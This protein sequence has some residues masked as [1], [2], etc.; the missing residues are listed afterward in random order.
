MVSPFFLDPAGQSAGYYGEDD[1]SLSNGQRAASILFKSEFSLSFV[2]LHG[3]YISALAV[4]L[5]NMPWKPS[6][7][8]SVPMTTQC[9]TPHLLDK[10]Y[11]RKNVLCMDSQLKYW[12]VTFSVC[13]WKLSRVNLW[14]FR[15][16]CQGLL[17][18]FLDWRQLFST[19]Y[20]G[21]VSSM[22]FLEQ[23]QYIL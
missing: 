14:A 15:F 22:W 6:G 8:C 13:M 21:T 23:I 12:C 9:F 10:C 3:F 2:G 16:Y 18:D 4:C 1:P 20:I 11:W 7:V 19:Y 17:I 5:R